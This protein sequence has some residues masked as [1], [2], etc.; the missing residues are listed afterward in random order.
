MQH[1]NLIVFSISVR[2]I[3]SGNVYNGKTTMGTSHCTERY[4]LHVYDNFM[5]LHKID[6]VN[7][8]LPFSRNH[9]RNTTISFNPTFTVACH[10]IDIQLNPRPFQQHFQQ[11]KTKSFCRKKTNNCGLQ[12]EC[13]SY[14]KMPHSYKKF[15]LAL[16]LFNLILNKV[17]MDQYVVIRRSC[18]TLTSTLVSTIKSCR[19]PV[20]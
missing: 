1:Q 10:P 17:F 9:S 20:T 2:S 8:H 6:S 14:E 5:Q 19:C 16:L 11:Q 15:D 3:I 13:A 4:H 18:Q 12:V 7:S